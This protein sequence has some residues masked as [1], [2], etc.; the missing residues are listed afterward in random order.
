M[1]ETNRYIT[2]SKGNYISSISKTV[3]LI[4][5]QENIS[6]MFEGCVNILSAMNQMLLHCHACKVTVVTNDTC[7]GF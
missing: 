4:N 1:H 3:Y 2:V 5:R 7:I 6:M